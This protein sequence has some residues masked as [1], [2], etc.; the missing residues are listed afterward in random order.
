[1]DWS[2]AR[3]RGDGGLTSDE[4][5][6]YSAPTIISRCWCWR[7]AFLSIQFRKGKEKK[8]WA[9]IKVFK[10]L[11]LLTSVVTRHRSV[12]R[13][14]GHLPHWIG[15]HHNMARNRNAP[16]VVWIAINGHHFIVHR[17]LDMKSERKFYPIIIDPHLE[18]NF[19]FY[20]HNNI[21]RV[22]CGAVINSSQISRW[23]FGWSLP[24]WSPSVLHWTD[25]FF[26]SFLP[27]ADLNLSS[28]HCPVYIRI[29]ARLKIVPLHFVD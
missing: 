21:V 18:A 4:L 11:L 5:A 12:G 24:V 19:P 25:V 10:G 7:R 26:F 29:L 27:P 6:I 2:T 8:K 9:K 20:H 23:A 1:M 16:P 14:D 3:A 15:L 28:L 22:D 17:R 13:S